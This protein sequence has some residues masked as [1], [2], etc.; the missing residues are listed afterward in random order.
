MR[1][2]MH[3]IHFCHVRNAFE[4]GNTACMR[5]I[6][7]DIGNGIFFKNSAK[8]P[9]R[10]QTFTRSNGK[11]HMVGNVFERIDIFLRHG[12]F[13][14]HGTHAFDL[15]ADFYGERGRHLAV[16]IKTE[17]AIIANPL[18]HGIGTF[19]KVIDHS[20]RFVGAPLAARSRFKSFVPPLFLKHFETL[21]R[22]IQPAF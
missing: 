5:A 21:T 4:F 19:D 18:A 13:D 16:K 12:F 8:L 1:H 14:K 7:L 20:G 2:N 10:K 17:F 3:V 9:A 11:R 6:G 15:V 22:S